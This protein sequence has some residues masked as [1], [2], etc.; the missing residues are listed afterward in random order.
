[1]ATQRLNE[2]VS[3]IKNHYIF[4]LTTNYW[5]AVTCGICTDVSFPDDSPNNTAFWWI[6]IDLWGCQNLSTLDVNSV[7]KPGE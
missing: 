3:I 7:S 4:S 6:T 5:L 2:P 1:M